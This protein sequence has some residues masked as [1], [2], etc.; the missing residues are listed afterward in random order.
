MNDQDIMKFWTIWNVDT[1][2]RIKNKVSTYLLVQT[3]G[4]RFHKVLQDKKDENYTI[5]E[6][7]KPPYRR[8]PYSWD[9]LGRQEFRA[10]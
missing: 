10:T 8:R 3:A 2:K 5:L 7:E 6:E 1:P 9:L 4:S